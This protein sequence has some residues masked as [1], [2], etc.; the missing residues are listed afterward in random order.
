MIL[1]DSFCQNAKARINE[2][3]TTENDTPLIVQFASNNVNDFIDA[4]KLVFPY[5]DGVDLNCGCP[6]RW[7]IRDGYGCA[8]LSKPEVVHDMVK[9]VRNS[10]P[11]DFSISVKIRIL[12][13]IK[14]TISLSQQLEK[15]GITFLTVHG[16]TPMQKS[17]DNIDT[18]AVKTVCESINIPVIANGGVKTLDD[19]NNLHNLT[20]CN[21]VMAASG[22]L[23]NPALFSG[24]KRT[25]M[26]CIKLWMNMKSMYQDKITFQCY[27]HH[28]VF[29]LEKVLTRQQKQVFNHLCTFESVDEFL[30]YNLLP[31]CD[32]S[33]PVKFNMKKLIICQYAEEITLK[34][35]RKC[36]SC[37]K[38]ISYC[39]CSK[40][41]YESNSGNF[42]NSYVQSFDHLD[43]MDS[44]MFEEIL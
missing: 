38:S 22:I 8:L 13:D 44:N 40:Y 2:F 1:A 34:H 4:S 18:Y 42:F 24:A 39:V 7:A 3:S 21:G 31:Q 6:Q 36:R 30:T 10:L 16:R 25:P 32:L 5:A 43:Y 14:K 37:G 27:H 26:T 12:E 20:E 41:D 28:L 33:S 19:A 35:S 9:E 29:M 17:G 15:C 23:V 11:S